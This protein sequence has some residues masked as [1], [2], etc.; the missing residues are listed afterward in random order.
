MEPHEIWVRLIGIAVFV[1]AVYFILRIPSAPKRRQTSEIFDETPLPR[2]VTAPVLF[3]NLCDAA[4]AR[5][6]RAQAEQ[7]A[8]Y[9]RRREVAMKWQGIIVDYILRTFPAG[10][11]GKDISAD[12]VEADDGRPLRIDIRSGDYELKVDIAA[13]MGTPEET[14][15]TL[16]AVA[17]FL[18]LLRVVLWDRRN[19]GVPN[20]T[21]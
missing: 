8:D 12:I 17:E 6:L 15:K 7:K 21:P 4:C 16:E 5:I 11:W 19:R 1:T 9:A 2:E 3:S 18:V 10:A 13:L 14:K 20:G